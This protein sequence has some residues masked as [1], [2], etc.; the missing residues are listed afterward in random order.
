MSKLL[1]GRM[2]AC[3]A[4]QAALTSK[5]TSILGFAIIVT[6][7]CTLTITSFQVSLTQDSSSSAQKQS[8]PKNL[9]SM[10]EKFLRRLESRI[11][12]LLPQCD[13]L[14]S[15][16][17]SY[18][19]DGG[20]LSRRTTP[21]AWTPR[22][23]DSMQLDLT[24]ICTLK[25]YTRDEARQCFA[26]KHVTF[27]GDSLTRYQFISFVYFMERGNYPPRFPRETPCPH[28]DE[29]GIPACSPPDQPNVCM[30]GDWK[31]LEGNPWSHFFSAI[32]GGEVHGTGIF[33]GRLQ[34]RCTRQDPVIVD[35]ELYVSE[36]DVHGNRTTLSYFKELGWDGRITN[37]S[38]FDFTD[39]IRT[40]SCRNSME[41]INETIKRAA[42]NDYDFNQPFPDAIDPATGVLRKHF[43]TVDYAFYNRFVILGKL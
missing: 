40:G 5:R 9:Q 38:G 28:V 6:S 20:F 7:L 39:C 16:P 22:A 11:P 1:H 24:A 10:E 32:G 3:I 42:A 4:N 27:V 31:S 36:P 15:R 43:P 19:A 2:A 26:D 8:S 41:D 21:H 29:N 34:C 12:K 23:D 35:N 25:R 14:M 37:I 30:E 13:E 33:N 17:N 18:F